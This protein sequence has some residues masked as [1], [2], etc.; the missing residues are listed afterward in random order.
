VLSGLLT[1]AS[2]QGIEHG[3]LDKPVL[4]NLKHYVA[5]EQELDRQLS[6]SNMDERTL[7]ELYNLPFEIAVTRSHP[8]SVMCSYNQINGTYACENPILNSVLKDEDGFDGYVMSDFG[9]VHS[10]APSLAAGMD[11]ELNRPRFLTPALLD[12]ALAAGTITQAQVDAAALRVVTAYIAGGLFDTPLPSVPVADAS[13]AAHKDIALHIAQRGSVLLKND[14]VLPLALAPG[15][16]IAVIGSTA[17]ATP[18]VGPSA[19]DLCSMPWRFGSPTTLTCEDLVPPLTAITE[20]AAANG[21]TVVYDDGSDVA[22]AANVASAADLAIAFGYQR[23]GE[24]S[25]LANLHLQGGG[26]SLVSEVAKANENTV[27]VLQTGS[28]VEMPWL[29]DVKAVLETWYAG[30]QMGPAMASILFGDVSPTGKLP[31]TFPKALADTPTGSDP[32]RYPGLLANGS[33]A[34]APGDTSIRQ[35]DYSEGL[36]VGYRWYQ[37]QGIEPLFPFGYGLSYRSF[38]Y[39]QLQVTPQSNDGTKE[40][41]IHFQLTNTGQR[42]GTETAQAY[43]T[44]PPSAAVPGTRLVGWEQVTLAPGESKNVQIRLSR[45]D[46]AELHL[47]QYFDSSSGRWSTPSG[48]FTISVGGSSQ[49]DLSQSFAVR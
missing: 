20:R 31:M 43:L 29:G 47:L 23:T 33:T 18:A 10:T 3:N 49:A 35:V 42:S 25:D 17:S 13:T 7:R 27:A 12:A 28:A 22:R 4:A 37:S 26:D 21:V 6:S 34:R 45:E 5:N 36:A 40:V 14:S 44:L 19:K 38:A 41:R 9:A 8:K 46:L 1:A 16:T 15:S 30:E 48:D 39:S 32:A 11:Q 2:V 24:F